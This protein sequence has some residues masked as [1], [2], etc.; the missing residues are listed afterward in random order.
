MLGV[1]KA[2]KKEKKWP[3]LMRCEKP[4]ENREHTT[5][6]WFSL[7]AML[8]E[9]TIDG[10]NHHLQLERAEAGW[11]CRL[12]GLVVTVDAALN[13][14]NVLSLLMNGKSYD[15]RRELTASGMNIWVGSIGYG[16][17]VRDPR[18][19]RGR[20]DGAGDNLSPK[21][22]VAPMPGSVVRGSVRVHAA[23]APGPCMST[24][25]AMN[26]QFATM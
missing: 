3:G 15:I 4:P 16:A 19:L 26:M 1:D 25:A 12:D 17:Q 9:V 11:R 22:L 24:V 14:P 6:N 20:K 2:L 18:A 10:K 7:H 23:A 5:R 8:Y 13:R 21:K